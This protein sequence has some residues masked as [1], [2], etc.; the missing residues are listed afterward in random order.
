[1]KLR[2]RTNKTPN[3]KEESKKEE[4]NL[5]MSMP[6]M[7]QNINLRVVSISRNN[8]FHLLAVDNTF[9]VCIFWNK[10]LL[11]HKLETS[12]LCLSCANKKPAHQTEAGP[13]SCCRAR[14]DV[15]SAFAQ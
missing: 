3:Q 10:Y 15:V 4:S 8:A 5:A 6:A 14:R 12:I 9:L 13:I 2:T 11:D 1:M 7:F